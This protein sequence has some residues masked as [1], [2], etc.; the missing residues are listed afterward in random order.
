ERIHI[1]S[2]Q[3]WLA[4]RRK[5]VTASVMGALF[6][7]DNH[8]TLGELH[9]EKSGLDLRRDENEGALDRGR[10]YEPYAIAQIARLRPDWRIEKADDYLRDT[11]HRIGA[12]IDA[13]I[14]D[15]RGRRGVLEIKTVYRPIYMRD[16][17]DGTVIPF[18]VTLQVATQMML[19]DADFG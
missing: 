7:V 13:R 17:L 5:D 19:D 10:F 4:E 6:G 15:G 12:T 16:W 1:T 18:P 8:R 11:R 3:Q 2:E 14:I 9:A